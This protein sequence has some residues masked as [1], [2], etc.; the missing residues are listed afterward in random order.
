MRR[1]GYDRYVAQGGDAGSVIS[2]ALGTIDPEHCAGVHVN[3]LMTF[4]SGDPADMADLTGEDMARLDCASS[5]STS[6]DT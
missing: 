6:P 1:L 5:T 2:Q 4:P 3:M